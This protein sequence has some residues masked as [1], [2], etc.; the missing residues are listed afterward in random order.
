MASDPKATLKVMPEDRVAALAGKKGVTVYKYTHDAPEGHME[1]AQQVHCYREICA[2]FDAGCRASKTASNEA[3]RE[4]VLEGHPDFRQFQRLYPKIFAAS[5]VRAVNSAVEFELE[6]ARKLYMLYMVERWTGKGN[7]EDKAARAMTFATR[8]SL[9]DTTEADRQGPL[10]TRLDD[11]PQAADLPK[12]TP[13][14]VST[15]GG[16]VINQT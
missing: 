14:D 6:K 5:T 15:F 2:G 16:K 11:L 12:L 4:Q 3:L 8:M 7:E 1:P 9:R 13:L 10:A